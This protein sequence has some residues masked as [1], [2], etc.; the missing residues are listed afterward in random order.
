MNLENLMYLNDGADPFSYF[1]RGGLGY[2]PPNNNIIGGTILYG[3]ISGEE[4]DYDKI[5][6]E[7]DEIKNILDTSTPQNN[8]NYD[9]LL[10]RYIDLTDTYA[11]LTYE[12]NPPENPK[13]YNYIESNISPGE[14]PLRD[15][16]LNDSFINNIEK[17]EELKQSGEYNPASYASL[18]G[19]A[20]EDTFIDNN[21]IFNII[22]EDET[23][24]S[25][26]N[27]KNFLSQHYADYIKDKYP[28]LSNLS[29]EEK[30]AYLMDR[31]MDELIKPEPP[32]PDDYP[33]R[34]ED[35]EYELDMD[36]YESLL[37]R[38]V[39]KPEEPIKPDIND[40]DD[41]EEYLL[42]MLNY[43]DDIKNFEKK[44]I[45]YIK[46]IN[47]KAEEKSSNRLKYFP[48]DF[49][50]ENAVYELKSYKNRLSDYKNTG[51]HLV[52]TKIEGFESFQPKFD[53]NK[54]LINV[55]DTY[56][57]KKQ[58][59]LSNNKP[60]E[61]Y[62]VFNLVDGVYVYKPSEDP[63][64]KVGKNGKAILNYPTKTSED[65]EG[66]NKK[67]EYLIPIN[68]LKRISN[69]KNLI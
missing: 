14:N 20:S 42:T 7:L 49:V 18:I 67:I 50:G 36:S 43:E 32:K 24:A 35:A 46:Y 13:I 19:D 6:N 68:K 15:T 9:T 48:Y 8:S 21:K 27:T 64:F 5:K 2:H 63:N 66:E 69:F 54:K 65:K 40:Y 56:G 33:E 47:E 11:H 29:F 10:N 44:Y 16:R 23:P 53:N 17:Y 55:I 12:E 30:E 39:E 52:N 31:Y 60:K 38:I 34:E 25:V 57:G 51:I 22:N 4:E 41:E 58:P 28:D 61:L 45:K 59:S 26:D 37:K 62:I 1:G 3:E